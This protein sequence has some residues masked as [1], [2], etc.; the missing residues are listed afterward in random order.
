L[1]DELDVRHCFGLQETQAASADTHPKHLLQRV[2]TWR[3]SIL[4]SKT[5]HKVLVEADIPIMKYYHS[6]LRITDSIRPSGCPQIT[7]LLALFFFI[8]I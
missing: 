6:T 3:Q 5:D 8:D 7:T 4:L 1:V 2:Q